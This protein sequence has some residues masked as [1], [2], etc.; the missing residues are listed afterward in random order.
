MSRLHVRKARAPADLER[1]Y[2]IN[3]EYL[4]AV[5]VVV[6]D[7]PES[8]RE[9]FG[10]RSGFWIAVADDATE[11]THAE[12]VAAGEAVGCIA[13]RPLPALGPHA[14]EVKRLYVR[15]SLR[16]HGLAHRL[17]DALE[18]FAAERGY[19]E[20]FLDTKD[21]LQAAIRFYTQ[22]GYVR[23][24]R[25]N[26]NPQATIFMSRMLPAC[27]TSARVL[28]MLRRWGRNVHAFDALEPGLEHWFAP[29]DAGVVAF[30][31]SAGWRVAVGSPICAREGLA[32]MAR[33]FSEDARRHGEEAVF[34]GVSDRFLEVLPKDGFDWVQ[35]GLQPSWDA[36]DWRRV[37]ESAP[38]LRY[39]VRRA[40]R[41]GIET[42]VV[43]PA[44]LEG[45]EPL[46]CEAEQLLAR[47]QRSHR[48][49]AMR[50]MVT[51]DLFTAL[52][53]RRYFAARRGGRLVGLLAAVPIYGR[54]G[55]LLDDLLIE[56][57]VAPGV[58][59]SLIDLAMRE[60]GAEGV[61]YVSLGLVALA[62]L[63]EG[64]AS[65]R[66]HPILGAAF[67]ASVRW[68]NG[69]YSFHGIYSFRDKLQPSAW[70]PVYMAASPRVSVRTLV[71]VLSAFSGG[72]LLRFGLRLAR[73]LLV[74]GGSE[75]LHR[76]TGRRFASV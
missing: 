48:M 52:H 69:L 51:V 46:R 14:C 59:E 70:E 54:G 49:P 40:G 29:D 19:T 41:A 8:F 61:A 20:V 3:V 24:A 30:A 62:G 50:F 63:G 34:F 60:L 66:A 56:R 27:G 15:P 7:S 35:I 57:G 22:R 28:S 10:S 1:A 45:A 58:A 31:R 2:A 76:V 26:D 16:G 33:A 64:R 21:D 37:W 72:S 65:P 44:A 4:D 42:A 9:Y 73:H 43:P 23:R 38:D 74:R 25:Y 53:E 47:W 18:T 32:G 12:E 71:A 67:N 75:I 17:L 55:W 6:R 39:M 68:L 36:R 13:L 11:A 5:D